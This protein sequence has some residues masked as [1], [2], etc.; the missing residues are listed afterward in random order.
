[1][2]RDE[3]KVP[4]A[5]GHAGGDDW[6][7][8]QL[9]ALRA[10]LAAGQ[11][12]ETADRLLAEITAA[13]AAETGEEDVDMLSLVLNDALDG[14]DI[15]RRYPNFYRR[16]L[17]DLDL[18]QAFLDALAI[19]EPEDL[20]D[21]EAF[22]QSLAVELGFLEDEVL[23]PLVEVAK[24]GWR[25]IWQRSVLQLEEILGIGSEPGAGLAWR[26]PQRPGAGALGEESIPLL[27]DTVRVG[28]R[29]VEVFLEAT[30][31][32]GPGRQLEPTLIVVGA[33]EAQPLQAILRWGRYEEITAIDA[34]GFA[35]LPAVPLAAIFDE[36]GLTALSLEI[37]ARPSTI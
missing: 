32:P 30:R 34:D 21:W 9:S 22:P 18:R 23:Q 3:D 26:G 37:V 8:E 25:I 6:V 35:R 15:A 28:E 36:T 14:V 31:P 4:S 11:W 27:R 5:S 7:Q 12:P 13:P 17:A 19:L 1:M 2:S 33:E 20:S 16:L 10:A 24:E 29:H